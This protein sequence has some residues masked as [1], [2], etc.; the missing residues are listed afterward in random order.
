MLRLSC[1]VHGP[2]YG[3]FVGFYGN[4]FLSSKPTYIVLINL[5]VFF[6]L[7]KYFLGNQ[8]KATKEKIKVL[9]S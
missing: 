4:D 1:V 7:I 5:K 9:V 2:I 6:F 3:R 8:I